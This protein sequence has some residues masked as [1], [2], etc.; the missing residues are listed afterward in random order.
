MAQGYRGKGRQGHFQKTGLEPATSRVGTG[1]FS[2]GL[3]LHNPSIPEPGTELSHEI[4]ALVEHGQDERALLFPV[5]IKHVM[6]LNT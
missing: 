4:H 1:C 3:C 2:T 5:Q 6:V